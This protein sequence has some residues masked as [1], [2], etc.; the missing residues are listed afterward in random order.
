MIKIF[1]V[2]ILQEESKEVLFHIAFTDSLYM[3]KRIIEFEQQYYMNDKISILMLEANKV[4]IDWKS[5]TVIEPE[6]IT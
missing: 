5:A 6:E 4:S 1:E 3:A 2:A